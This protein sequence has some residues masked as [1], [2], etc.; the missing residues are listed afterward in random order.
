M[1]N[2]DWIVN[3]SNLPWLELDITFPHE[4]MLQEAI[5]LKR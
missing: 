3:E 1:S 4:E 2:F 5:N